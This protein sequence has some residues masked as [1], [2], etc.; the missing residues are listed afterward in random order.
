MVILY[1]TGV[2][3]FRLR[4]ILNDYVWS[5]HQDGSCSKIRENLFNGPD[6]PL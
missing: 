3:G 2:N 1:R 6:T 4:F 5:I